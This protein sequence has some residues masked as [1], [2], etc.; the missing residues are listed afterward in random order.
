MLMLG[1]DDDAIAILERAHHRVPR[2]RRDAA[3]GARRDLDRHE[4]RLPRARSARRAAG[5]VARSGS[6]IRSRTEAAEH[7]YLL[8]PHVFRHEAAG[9]FEAAAAVAGE[10][11]AIGERFGDAISSRWVCTPR[12]T[13]SSR[14]GHVRE[15]LALLDEAMVT[16]TTPRALAVRRRHR[17][18]RRHPR[19]P[20]GLRGRAGARVDARADGLGGAAARISS[21]SPAAASST[22]RR[23]CSSSGSWSDALEEARRA[24]RRFVE[25]KNPAAGI[26]HYRAGASFSG[27]AGS[28]Q[29]R[30][31]R[32]AR[33][34][35][36]AGSRN[37]GS[38]SFGWR[39]GR[40]TRHSQPSAA[41]APRSPSR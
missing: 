24:G 12:A 35:A 19:L 39:R 30:R 23:S 2:A 36:A 3:R 5:S 16:V 17:L 13:C 22:G 41:R 8:I 27:C 31:R 11:A 38:R 37:R 14:A 32:T 1:R 7:G 34:A 40:P 33:R 6:S 25:T 20:G 15:G 18:L 4:P 21:P 26:A 29:P 10:A 9:D 28:S